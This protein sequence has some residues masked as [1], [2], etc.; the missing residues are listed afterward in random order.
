[1]SI[2]FTCTNKNMRN[3]LKK[4]INTMKFKEKNIL[5][6]NMLKFDINEL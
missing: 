2:N 4:T 5:A 1:M 6:Q 3:T